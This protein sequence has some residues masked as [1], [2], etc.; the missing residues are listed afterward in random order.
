[1][2]DFISGIHN[3][4]DRWR[5][6][7]AFTARCRAADAESDMTDEER[8]IHN[9]A[10]WRKLAAV[11]AEAQ[12]MLTEKAEEFGID[13][14]AVSDEKIA[15]VLEREDEFVEND[16]LAKL[17]L[18]YLKDST[19]ALE[20]KDDWLIF[21]APGEETKNEMLEIICWYQFF[22]SAKI[23]RGLHGLLDLDGNFDESEL[24]D[25]RSDAN[26]SVKI[27]LIAVERSI[28]A[29]TV[30]MTNENSRTI[31]PLLHLLETV[32]QTAEKKFP[33]AYQ[34]VRPGFD[35]IET[36]M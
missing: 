1:M 28:M 15:A 8:D 35:E 7:C 10:F 4:C 16:I 6:R 14:E 26:G 17:S 3:Y 31:K 2:P 5:E 18:K 36:V 29:W 24:N 11:F 32:R 34:F 20:K 25:T 13:L 23:R 22:I 19:T 33:N 12:I 27:A 9:E 30:L 21:S